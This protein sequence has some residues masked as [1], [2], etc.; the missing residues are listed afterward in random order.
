ML[1]DFR[2]NLKHTMLIC[3]SILLKVSRG[4]CLK[5][6]QQETL[7]LYPDLTLCY[8][9]RRGLGQCMKNNFPTISSLSSTPLESFRTQPVNVPV[10]GS[11]EIIF[12]GIVV[13]SI[14]LSSVGS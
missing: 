10:N 11:L 6:V 2:L 9:V 8:V 12:T 7:M 4:K 1:S 3:L 5:I 13:F 14:H